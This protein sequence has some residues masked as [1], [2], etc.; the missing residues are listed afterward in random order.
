MT[1]SLDD[2]TP[3]KPQYFTREQMHAICW[4]DGWQYATVWRFA[5]PADPINMPDPPDGEG[6]EINVDRGEDGAQ[7]TVPRWSDGS[8]VMQ[9]VYWRRES[10]GM[11]PWMLKAHINEQRP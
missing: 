8:R 4:V 11:E 5:G 2:E 6:W 7:V 10:K 1:E 9:H 3:E